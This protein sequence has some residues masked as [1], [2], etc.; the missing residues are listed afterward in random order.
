VLSSHPPKD[1]GAQIDGIARPILAL[2]VPASMFLVMFAPDIVRLVFLRG[3]F[4][5]HALLLTSAALRGIGCGLWAATLGWILIRILNGAGRNFAAAAIII[6]AYVANIVVNLLT[7][8]LPQGTEYGTLLL[9]LGEAV[10]GIVL[11]GGIMIA[12]TARRR[13]LFLIFLSSFPAALMV[14]LGWR[15]HDLFDGTWQRL[16]AGGFAC[17]ICVAISVAMLMPGFYVAAI[18]RIRGRL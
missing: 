12:L 18:A 4:N 5:E 13:I 10:R 7:S 16:F 6:S 14:F 1:L 17:L 15:I 8:Y 9:G 3:A 2:S 11:L